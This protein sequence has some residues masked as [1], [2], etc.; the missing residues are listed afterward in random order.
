MSLSAELR[1]RLDEL[2]RSGD[3]VLFMKGTRDAPQCGFSAATVDILDRLVP[4]YQTIDV[5]SESEIREGIKEFSDWPTIPQ[6]YVHGEFVGGCDIIREM[7]ANGELYETLGLSPPGGRDPQILITEKA[8]QVLSS[9][10]EQS[11]GSELHLAIDARF[12]SKVGLGPRRGG[13]IE[14]ESNGIRLLLDAESAARA[15]GIT[16]D[17]VDPSKGPALAL[18]NPNAPEAGASLRRD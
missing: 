5:L 18:D 17:A 12:Q 4:E 3:V 2:S 7:Y 9:A 11:P 16:V 14:V 15:D 13:E 8:A 10:T 6:L 1:S